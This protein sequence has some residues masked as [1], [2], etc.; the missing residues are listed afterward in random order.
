MGQVQEVQEYSACECSSVTN[1]THYDQLL[2]VLASYGTLG[3]DGPQVSKKRNEMA[4]LYHICRT[5]EETHMAWLADVNRSLLQPST[6]RRIVDV[7]HFEWSGH[8]GDA[9]YCP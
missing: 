6:M 3:D 9:N 1:R 5:S 7:V 4:N 2:K 8:V